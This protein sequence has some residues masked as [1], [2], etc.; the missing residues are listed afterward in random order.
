MT[1]AALLHHDRE[2]LLSR[3][4]EARSRTDEIF[5]AVLDPGALYERP[6][7][8][9]H[10]LVF[11]LGHVEAFDW[12]LLAR[13]A[14]GMDSFHEPFDRLFAFG[15]D[16]VDGGLPS[17][18]AS[19]WPPRKAI[20]VYNRRTRRVIDE[21]LTGRRRPAAEA[22][23]ATLVHMAIEH[24]LMHAETLA[25]L[26]HE[27]PPAAKRPP[28][29][30]A[31]APSPATRPTPATWVEIPAGRA[32][33]GRRRG[34]GFGWDNEYEAIEVEVPAFAIERHKVTNRRFLEFLGDNGYR[35]RDLWSAADW[36]W[37]EREDVRHPR[38]W[39]ERDGAWLY[40]GMFGEVPLPLE[41]P[42]YVSHAEASAFARWSGATLPTEAQFHRAAHGAPDG[43]E[44]DYPWGDEAPGERHGNFDF[45]AW[46]PTP[47]GAH[48]GG[49]SAFGVSELVGNGWEWTRTL[50]EPFPGFRAHPLYAGYSANSFDGHHYVLKGGSPRTAGCMLR[51]SFRNWFQPRYPYAYAAFRL[52]AP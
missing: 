49:D 8:E 3:L 41:A 27:L 34:P 7:P 35:R 24:R 26:L 4:G 37:R 6:I 17:E 14:F 33:L 12:N 5:D 23:E 19:D 42:A 20:E 32:T 13:G 46:D 22:D 50:F 11:Y 36:A 2:L 51:R 43:G 1:N 10:R 31:T 30:D 25:Y 52:V 21:C 40:R 15:I 16:P 28:A 9:R 44:R 38:P 48:P 29:D 18:P 47:V 45:H 39:V